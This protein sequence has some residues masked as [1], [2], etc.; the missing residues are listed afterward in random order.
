MIDRLS[1]AINLHPGV[2]SPNICATGHLEEDV[3]KPGAG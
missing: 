3:R 1:T 2:R